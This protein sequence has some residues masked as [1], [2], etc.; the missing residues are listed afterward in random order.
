MNEE[1]T[2]DLVVTLEGTK[3]QDLTLS[4]ITELGWQKEGFNF[5]GWTTSPESTVIYAKD[6]ATEKF[7]NDTDLYAIWNSNDYFCLAAQESNCSVGLILAN[8][9]IKIEVSR[10]AE[11]WSNLVEGTNKYLLP[12][13]GD[14]LYFRAKAKNTLTS[15]YSST[16]FSS[17]KQIA[18]YGNILS[19]KDPNMHVDIIDNEDYRYMFGNTD[20]KLVKA[21]SLKC[22]E[23][24]KVIGS[25]VFHN[26]FQNSQITELPEFPSLPS[27]AYLSE[28]MFYGCKKLTDIV[29]PG[30]CLIIQNECFINC[31]NLK[32]VKIENGVQRINS[33]AFAYDNNMISVILPQTLT[34]IENFAFPGNSSSTTSMLVSIDLTAFQPED[35]P[36][37]IGSSAFGSSDTQP[38]KRKFYFSSQE[39]LDKFA[40]QQNWSALSSHFAVKA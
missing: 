39:T 16:R 21:P 2:E 3:G 6:G 12:E 32:T 30:S 27:N 11:N 23:K 15:G 22:L 17:S 35:K 31:Y 20:C 26:T 25:N 19:L 5:G 29:I 34:N 38:T 36:P 7:F 13:A 10:D 24:V 40:L 28:Q 33:Y 1:I 14:K 37:T 9:I 18:A 4:S 8:T